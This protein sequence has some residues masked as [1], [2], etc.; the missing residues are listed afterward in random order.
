MYLAPCFCVFLCRNVGRCPCILAPLLHC[1]L[2]RAA[3]MFSSQWQRGSR[4]TSGPD[5]ITLRRNHSSA[6]GRA[7][8]IC[9]CFWL[10]LREAASRQAKCFYRTY[11]GMRQ[12][13]RTCC[14]AVRSEG[15]HVDVSSYSPPFALGGA[16]VRGPHWPTCEETIACHIQFLH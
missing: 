3:A 11:R 4:S 15:G 10:K 8:R 12:Q 13:S 16:E 2:V 6:R 1:D 14:E 5:A 9:G 7:R